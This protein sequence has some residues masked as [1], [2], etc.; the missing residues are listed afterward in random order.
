MN[1]VRIKNNC[2]CLPSLSFHDKITIQVFRK[3]DTRTNEMNP[4]THI[5]EELKTVVCH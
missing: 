1:H 5:K 3:R 4:S 2:V